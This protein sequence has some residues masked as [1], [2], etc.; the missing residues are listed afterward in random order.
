MSATSCTKVNQIN[1]TAAYLENAVRVVD[2]ELQFVD[3]PLVFVKI[4]TSAAMLLVV[5]YGAVGVLTKRQHFGH[6]N[7]SLARGGVGL[8]R[9]ASST[10]LQQGS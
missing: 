9:A 1:V 5:A 7:A 3:S 10:T 6:L 4:A 2:S 8:V